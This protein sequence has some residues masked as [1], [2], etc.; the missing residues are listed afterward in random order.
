MYYD[1]ERIF[2][3][4]QLKAYVRIGDLVRKENE[5]EENKDAKP[6]AVLPIGVSASFY[7]PT[8][9]LVAEIT[10]MKEKYLKQKSGQ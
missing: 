4:E 8:D 6:P 9:K 1:D 10:D 5:N 2:S 7:Q 3:I